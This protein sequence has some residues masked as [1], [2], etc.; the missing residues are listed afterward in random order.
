MNLMWIYEH[1]FHFEKPQKKADTK[2]E[3]TQWN[4]APPPPSFYCSSSDI[5]LH[6]AQPPS[7]PLDSHRKKIEEPILL[8]GKFN[9][10]FCCIAV[11]GN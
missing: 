11:P 7:E 2:L 10:S 9:S 8:V 3:L 5:N 6:L 1:M 4:F